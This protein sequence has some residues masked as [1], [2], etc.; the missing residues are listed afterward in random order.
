MKRH[1]QT[2]VK[3]AGGWPSLS[4]MVGPVVAPSLSRFVRQGGEF[5]FFEKTREK[6]GQTEDSPFFGQSESGN[7]PSVPGF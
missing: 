4:R 6:P 7:V 2:D 5:D 1:K 3:K